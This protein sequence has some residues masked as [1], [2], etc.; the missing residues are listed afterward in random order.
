[1]VYV[2]KFLHRVSFVLVS[3]SFGEW[4]VYK[5]CRQPLQILLEATDLLKLI[6]LALKDALRLLDF[7][8]ALDRFVVIVV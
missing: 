2:L 4:A 3:S 7:P 1:M 5:T 8:A 6:I